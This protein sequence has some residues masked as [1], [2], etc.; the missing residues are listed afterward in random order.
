ML[1]QGD[2]GEV[3]NSLCVNFLLYV[4]LIIVFYMLMRFYL[5]E[6]T[7]TTENYIYQNGQTELEILQS[8]PV[9][10]DGNVEFVSMKTE[11]DMSPISPQK[12]VAVRTGSFL[13]V[14][15]WGEPLGTKHEVIQSVF[16]CAFG[17]HCTFLLW[18]LL[19]ERML[20][21]TY[22][23]DFFVYSYGLVF[24]NRLGSV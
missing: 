13:N 12:N 5:E 6:E 10:A 14:N 19:Q 2:L 22:N 17:L 4:V 7:I 24:I 1:K 21:Q 3:I 8:E 11:V 18:G 9:S 15:E 20:T 23:G 16:F